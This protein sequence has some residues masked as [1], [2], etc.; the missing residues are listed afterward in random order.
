M[1]D[2]Q[3]TGDNHAEISSL[4]A[5]CQ[6][7]L[8]KVVLVTNEFFFFKSG[9]KKQTSGTIFRDIRAG[10]NTLPKNYGRAGYWSKSVEND[11]RDASC[12]CLRRP[13]ILG[14]RHYIF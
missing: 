14:S 1:K 11:F 5:A 3:G 6:R 13:D 12:V 8:Q 4:I 7:C 9:I 2:R 10:K